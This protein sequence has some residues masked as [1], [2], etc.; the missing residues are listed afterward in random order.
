MLSFNQSSRYFTAGLWGRFSVLFFS[1]IVLAACQP[2]AEGV[3]VAR[4]QPLLV[5]S[6]TIAIEVEITSQGNFATYSDQVRF[7][8][9][10]REYFNRGRGTL[11]AETTTIGDSEEL[12]RDRAE[13]IYAFLRTKGLKQNQLTV[14]AGTAGSL[15]DRG[16]LL[17]YAANNVELPECGDWSDLYEF[18][19]DNTPRKNF[20][21]SV[22]RNLGLIV[23]DPGDLI[24]ARPMTNRPAIRSDA[25]VD[26][27]KHGEATASEKSAAQGDGLGGE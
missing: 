11:V 26:G 24:H 17:Y 7:N 21:C 22:Q 16:V 20:G 5:S 23:S 4:A 18:N 9:F 27:Y 19:P 8:K 3:D 6:G 25:V 2:P 12:T 10:M 15:G 13:R 1:L 14:M